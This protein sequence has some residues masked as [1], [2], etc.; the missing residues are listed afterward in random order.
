MAHCDGMSFEQFAADETTTDAVLLC[1]IHVGEASKRL[2]IEAR[3]EFPRFPWQSMIGMRNVLVHEYGRID[4][5]R[6]W[7][8]LTEHLPPLRDELEAYLSRIP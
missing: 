3:T 4:Y 5:V 8:I 2:S 1:L 7:D 6:V